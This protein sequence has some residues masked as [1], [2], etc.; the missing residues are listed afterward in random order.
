MVYKFLYILLNKV[1][2]TF[3]AQIFIKLIEF[4]KLE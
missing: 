2:E 3:V 4:E 1:I